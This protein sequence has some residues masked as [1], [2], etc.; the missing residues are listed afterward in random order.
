[1]GESEGRDMLPA[2]AIVGR[3]SG[4]SVASS[5][6]SASWNRLQTRRPLGGAVHGIGAGEGANEA[7]DL[8]AHRQADVVVD[9][10]VD[11]GPPPGGGRLP[12]AVGHV[13]GRL[14]K[15]VPDNGPPGAHDGRIA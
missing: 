1:M 11:A 13:V 15:V 5:V 3:V 2:L 9:H 4:A 12:G 14:R 6:R 8:A 10:V 7:P